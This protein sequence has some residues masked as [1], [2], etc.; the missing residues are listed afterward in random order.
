MEKL[1]KKYADKLVV[2]GLSK[3]DDL[4]IGGLDAELV[5]NREHPLCGVL[6]EVV[7]GLNIN[8]ILFARPAEPYFSIV[9][10]LIN[11][12]DSDKG[13]IYPEDCETRTFLHDI[14]VVRGFTAKNIV[15]ALKR[16]KSVIVADYGIVT[17][18]TVSPE[19]AFV[20]F[21]SVCF[22]KLPILSSMLA[23]TL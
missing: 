4:I 15:Y 21:S 5:W 19:Q 10:Y 6:E 18:G 14:S 20:T 16:R 13:A 9:N 7:R 17:F 2:Q 23:K 12:I 3:G 8:S 11:K 1:I 22:S